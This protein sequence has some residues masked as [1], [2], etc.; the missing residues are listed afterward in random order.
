MQFHVQ[1]WDQVKNGNK[2]K[3]VQGREEIDMLF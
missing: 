1:A 2:E 3:N